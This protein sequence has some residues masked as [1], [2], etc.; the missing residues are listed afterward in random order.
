MH[1]RVLFMQNMCYDEVMDNFDADASIDNVS[2][3]GCAIA[4]LPA[5]GH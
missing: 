5:S 4:V 2:C 1:M 3:G